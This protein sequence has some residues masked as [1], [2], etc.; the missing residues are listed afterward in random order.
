MIASFLI[1]VPDS[2]NASKDIVSWASPFGMQPIHFSFVLLSIGSIYTAIIQ[3]VR[4]RRFEN[5]RPNI[6]VVPTV[7]N[8]RAILEVRNMGAEADFTAKARVIASQPEPELF[9]MYW[10]S[11]RNA[12]C[13]IDGGGGIATI[14]V[15]EK[16][17]QDNRTRD[18]ETFYLR[19]DLVI[20]KMGTSGEQV[21]PVFSGERQMLTENGQRVISGTA[22]S[23][24]IV[25]VTITATPRLKKNGGTHRYL[26]EIANQNIEISKTILSS[27][28]KVSYQNLSG[29]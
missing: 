13:H 7:K 16:A 4:I 21:F 22:I 6:S 2:F 25:E 28:H 9:T 20:F 8:D 11:N 23:R 12:H 29:S 18:V 1:G 24:C 10:E 15:G 27:P 19:G 17:K 14:L 3:A 26:V 5:T